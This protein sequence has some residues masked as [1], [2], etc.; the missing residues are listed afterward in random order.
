[1]HESIQ[2]DQTADRG[3][4]LEYGTLI[5]GDDNQRGNEDDHNGYQSRMG[6]DT[7]GGD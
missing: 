4:L 5:C 2:V 6:N 3:G 7:A 1:M